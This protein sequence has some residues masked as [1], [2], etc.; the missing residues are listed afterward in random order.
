MN[1]WAIIEVTAS[2]VFRE[3]EKKNR[4]D[5]KDRNEVI[6]CNILGS[7]S[8]SLCL[9]KAIRLGEATII[10]VQLVS[11]TNNCSFSTC[12]T[13]RLSNKS[14]RF[15]TDKRNICSNLKQVP[16][17]SLSDCFLMISSRRSIFAT[18]LVHAHVILNFYRILSKYNGINMSNTWQKPVNKDV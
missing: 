9:I 8:L 16:L 7:T 11:G 6:C 14:A 15:S 4:L 3:K 18:L 2:I 10:C 12:Q 17:L 13:S 1:V 5:R